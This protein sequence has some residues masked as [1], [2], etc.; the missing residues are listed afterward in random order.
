MNT[1]NKRG[2]NVFVSRITSF[3]SIIFHKF[4]YAKNKYANE[5]LEPRQQFQS[6][7]CFFSGILQNIAVFSRNRNASRC[8]EIIVLLIDVASAD[9]W[10][11]ANQARRGAFSSST[12]PPSLSSPITIRDLIAKPQAEPCTS[13]DALLHH[14][15]EYKACSS[16]TTVHSARQL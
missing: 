7:S 1:T 4:V 11:L 5:L 9:E 2:A 6:V 16:P 12:F 8:D 3:T 14:A 10:R 15:H 13:H